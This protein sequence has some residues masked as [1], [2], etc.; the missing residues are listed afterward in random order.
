M[1]KRKQG[2][3]WEYGYKKY[4]G[5]GADE[6]KKTVKRRENYFSDGASTFCTRRIS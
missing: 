3:Y 1:S 5:I 4:G 6:T 2:R